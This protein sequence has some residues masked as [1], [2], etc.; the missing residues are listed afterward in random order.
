M[1]CYT[2]GDLTRKKVR[3]D[4][5]GGDWDTFSAHVEATPVG[6]SEQLGIFL[7]TDE[8]TPPL[9][10]GS[11]VYG[12]TGDTLRLM[13][14]LKEPSQNCR[15]IVEGRALSMRLHLTQLNPEFFSESEGRA[16]RLLLTGGASANRAIR[17]IFADVFGRPVVTADVPDSAAVG[18]A[19][20]ARHGA[21]G[22]ASLP[23]AKVRGEVVR[24][25]RQHAE[26]YARLL[27]A[28]EALDVRS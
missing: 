12:S 7:S 22:A 2:N 23:E 15:A 26:T 5:A 13:D 16:P 25:R 3:D 14:S 20:R 27:A 19:M 1:L 6:N 10:Q 17:Q 18:A 4:F 11:T 21:L 28:Y 8:I 9:S 24:P